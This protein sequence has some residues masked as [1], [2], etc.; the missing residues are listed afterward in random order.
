[1]NKLNYFVLCE[2]IRDFCIK[3]NLFTLGSSSQYDSVLLKYKGY[4]TIRD[5]KDMCQII[6]NY[7]DTDY[8]TA[9]LFCLFLK[10][11]VELIK[12]ER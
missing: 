6:K 4:H 11:F 8:T 10:E 1:M 5:A 7:S 2:D 12:E 9:D 3:Y